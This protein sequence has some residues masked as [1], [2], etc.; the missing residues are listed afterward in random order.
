MTK[1]FFK[2]FLSSLIAL[3]M[4]VSLV[5]IPSS[6]ATATISKTSFNLT[7]G[8]ATTL[9]VEG[10]SGTVTWSTGDKTI[11]TVNSSGRVIGKG[12]GTTYIY[13]KVNGETLKSKVTVVAGKIAVGKTTVS[14]DSGDTTTVKIKAIGTHTLS[15]SSSDKSVVKASWNGAKFDG[16]YVNLTLQAVG[17][18]TAK[19][20]VYA[21]NYSSTVYKYI[22]VTVDGA[23]LSDDGS[24]T[25]Q[26]VSSVSSVS[27]NAGESSTFSVYS[28]SSSTSS[29]KAS[30]ANSSI[31]TVSISGTKVTVTGVAAGTTSVKVYVS[32]NTSTYITV[33]VTVS[34]SSSYYV[35]SS[36]RP[37][38]MVSTDQIV[39]I[40]ITQYTERYMLVPYGY[41][42]AYVNTVIAQYVGTHSYYTIYDSQPT[43]LLSSDTILTKTVTLNGQSVIR[44]V[45]VPTGYDTAKA[46]TVFAKYSSTYEYY[47]VYTSYPTLLAYS[48]VVKSWTIETVD[49]STGTTSTSSRY[50]LVPYSYDSTKVDLLIENDKSANQVTSIYK[51]LTTMP[52]NYNA[53]VYELIT[54]TN[55]GS[56]RYM[57]V[58]ISNCDYVK[59]N[60]AVQ[61]DMG[62]YCYYVVY[63]TKP[64][65]TNSSVEAV[66]TGSILSADGNSSR[67]VYI[68]YNPSDTDFATKISA[69]ITGSDYI[70]IKQGSVS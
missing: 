50:M 65:V 33:P 3:L 22:T 53:S 56:N 52:T 57:I 69:A 9:S 34:A 49:E 58:P 55:N 2:S 45:L 66:W 64:T 31:A 18:G 24:T 7:K 26:L 15:V 29:L 14:L 30:S 38:K 17:E 37:T 54:W 19:V 68:L 47:V 61:A 13:A 42:E 39:T 60:D 16:D 32:G 11:A 48:D 59:R 5:A 70:G 41:D 1:C 43:K 12:L 6:A 35:I 67:R 23:D 63:S 8:Y 36:T 40:K 4:I 46:A 51:V 28:L 62:V 44:Y 10:A 25:S 21:K 20:K 27:V